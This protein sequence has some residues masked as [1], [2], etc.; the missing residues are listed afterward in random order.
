MRS[1]ARCRDCT[2]H[3]VDAR[4]VVFDRVL[5]RDD[6]AVWAVQVVE[7][8]VQGGGLSRTGRPGHQDDPV[9][10]LDRA[11]GSSGSRPRESPS[12]RKPTLMLSLSRIRMTTDWPWLVGSTLT[13]RSSSLSPTVTLIRPSWGRR[14]SAMS[15]LARILMRGQDRAQ[16][17]AGGAV[18]LDQHAVDPVADADPILERLDVDVRGPQLH[19]LGNDQLHQPDDRGTRLVDDFGRRGRSCR[20]SR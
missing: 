18:A 11:A 20:R 14:R 19:G 8:R 2:S 13:R 12:C 5:G 9:G 3:L 16:Q 15:I 10:P 17:P 7:R 1:P 6:L 4:Q